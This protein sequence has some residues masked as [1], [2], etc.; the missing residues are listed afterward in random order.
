[1]MTY[2]DALPIPP[3]RPE[4][5]QR[6][7]TLCNGGPWHGARISHLP[8][9]S[10]PRLVERPKGGHFGKYVLHGDTWVWH[11]FVHTDD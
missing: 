4:P 5:P 8:G 3:V 11:K 1:M 10:T 6:V 2:D 9:D 7:K